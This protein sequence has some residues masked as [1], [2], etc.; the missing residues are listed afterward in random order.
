MHSE[1]GAPAGSGGSLDSGMIAGRLPYNS[2]RHVIVNGKEVMQKI[3]YK[4][5]AVMPAPGLILHI[6]G[7]CASSQP[8]CPVRLSCSTQLSLAAALCAEAGGCSRLTAQPVL[9]LGSCPG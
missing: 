6:L 7:G 4:W 5:Q 1:A 2:F 8:S 3:K 9:L